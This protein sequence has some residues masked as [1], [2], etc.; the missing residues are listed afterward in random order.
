ML[1][2]DQ[3]EILDDAI[4]LL[5]DLGDSVLAERLCRR[6]AAGMGLRYPSTYDSTPGKVISLAFG[7]EDPEDR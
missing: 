6:L 1:S 4:L 7:R 2:E 5:V 3:I